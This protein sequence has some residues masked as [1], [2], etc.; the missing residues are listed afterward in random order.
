MNC[1]LN[2]I[3]TL[4]LMILFKNAEVYTPELIGRKDILIG[5]EQRDGV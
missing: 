4:L 1:C 5:G 2:M 3:K